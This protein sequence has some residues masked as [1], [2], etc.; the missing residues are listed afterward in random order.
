MH[1]DDF[2]DFLYEALCLNFATRHIIHTRDMLSV[3]S[4]IVQRKGCLPIRVTPNRQHFH[5]LY[6]TPSYEMRDFSL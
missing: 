3:E 5:H 1:A 4:L 6:V 2:G